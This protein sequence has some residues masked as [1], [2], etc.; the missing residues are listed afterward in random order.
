MEKK[1]PSKSSRSPSIGHAVVTSIPH[2]PKTPLLAGDDDDDLTDD[3]EDLR[4]MELHASECR[5]YVH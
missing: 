3:D 2:S 1:S 4:H 5:T